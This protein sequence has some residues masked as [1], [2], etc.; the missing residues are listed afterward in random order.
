[1]AENAQALY[2]PGRIRQG[3]LA[4]A[5]LMVGLLAIAGGE[6]DIEPEWTAR[7]RGSRNVSLG[8]DFE[9]EWDILVQAL[10]IERWEG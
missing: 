10:G 6:A 1:M 5:A 4:T 9:E 3:D 2:G 8:P 7:S